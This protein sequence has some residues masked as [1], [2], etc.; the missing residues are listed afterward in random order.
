MKAFKSIGDGTS[1]LGVLLDKGQWHGTKAI[2]V[3]R[4]GYWD[5]CLEQVALKA[6]LS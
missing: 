6:D 3:S 1:L 5:T 4:L 2:D